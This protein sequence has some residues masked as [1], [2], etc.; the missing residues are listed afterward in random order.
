MK[1]SKMTALIG[2]V[3]EFD[4]QKEDVTAYLERFELFLAAN[5]IV[6]EVKKRSVFLSTVGPRTYKL[7][8]SLA[9]NKP[10][11]LTFEALSKLLRDHLQPRPNT[12]AQRYKFFKRDRL[13]S[14]TVTEYLAA[15]NSLSEF[16]E[17][18]GNLMST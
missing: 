15:L 6:D 1:P 5:D 10:L 7:I 9:N 18:G 16:C 17:F 13:P 3:S 11:E 2:N 12:I 14:E 8:R 4:N